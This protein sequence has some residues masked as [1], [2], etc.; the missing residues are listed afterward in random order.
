GISTPQK[1]GYWYQPGGIA[2]PDGHCRPFDASAQGTVI[3]NGVGVVVLKRL[4]DAIRDRDKIEAVIK[5]FALNN[6]GSTKVGYTAPSIDGQTNA[7][8]MA[9]QMAHVEPDTIGYIEGHGT[10]TTVGDPIEVAALTKAFR[11]RTDKR[12]FCAIGSLKSNVGHLGSAAGVAGLIKGVLTVKHGQIPKSLH[13]EQPNPEIDFE[14]SPFFVATDLI[15]W[16]IKGQV[17]RAGVSSFGVGGTNAHVVLEQAPELEGGAEAAEKQLLVLSTRTATALEKLTD[18]LVAHLERTPVI[19][20]AD[21][22]FT[23]QI[24]RATFPQRRFMVFDRSNRSDLIATLK[25]RDPQRVISAET[26]MRGR[27]VVFMFSGQGTQH[28]GMALGLYQTE[29]TFRTQ[30]HPCF[31]I[32]Q[33]EMG[34]DRRE[35]IY[36]SGDREAAAA[37]LRQTAITQPALFTIEYALARL[38]MECG[39]Q[40]SAILG[41]SIGEYVAACLAGVMSL[42]DAL[43]VVAM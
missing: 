24:G 27:P 36:P 38:W 35:I 31:E 18:N 3:G 9:Q 17:R 14:K 11:E 13:Y 23:C 1:K 7:I 41:H 21:V 20:L 34:L 26:E 37:R 19:D 39:I 22:A 30:V 5:G 25:A 12:Q 33:G 42:E 16:P 29:Y 28:V 10:G 4:S 32:L 2:S 43:S 40:P 8:R 15:D 6:D